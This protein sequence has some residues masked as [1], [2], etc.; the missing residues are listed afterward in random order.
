VEQASVNSIELIRPIV[1]LVALTGIVWALMVVVRN[2]AVFRGA[3]SIGY[4]RGYTGNAPPEWIERP[5]RAFM[6]LLEV[7]VL[8]YV[9][10]LLML[11]TQRFDATQVA[12]AWT[13][14]A[15]RA[16]HAAIHIGWNDVRFRFFAYLSGCLVLAAIWVR[17][18][19]SLA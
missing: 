16:A 5:A 17:F 4:Y 19:I 2:T 9:V 11:V 18:A 6:N 14:V 12:L 3:A 7:P 15:L 13:F 10:C 1:A 8:F